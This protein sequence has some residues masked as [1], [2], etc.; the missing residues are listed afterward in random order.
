MKLKAIDAIRFGGLKGACVSDLGDGLTVVLGPNESGKSSLTALAR[1]VLYGYPDG[2]SKERGYVPA[3]GG[4]RAARLVFADAAGEW[5]VE[6][7]DG[8]NRGPV[9][10]ATLAGSARPE[11]LSE[12]VSGVSEQTYKVVFGFGLDELALIEHGDKD[13]VLARLHAAGAG[14]AVNPM[15]ARKRLDDEAKALYLKGASKPQVNALAAQIRD[16][17]LRIA[18]LENVASDYAADQVCLAELAEQLE[19]LRE[20]RDA[21]RAQAHVFEQ[22]TA[23]LEGASEELVVLAGDSRDSRL[24]VERIEKAL[25][26]VDVDERVLAVDAELSAVLDE[27]SGF[28]QRLESLREADVA[29]S[30]VERRAATFALPDGAVDSIENRTAVETWRDRLTGLRGGAE[31]EEYTARQAEAR[32]AGTEQIAAETTAPASGRANSRVLAVVLATIIVAAGLVFAATGVLLRQPIATVLGGAVVAAGAI[33]LVVAITRKPVAA[34]PS[35]LSAAAAT[36]RADA[37]AQRTLATHSSGELDRAFGEWRAWLT[38]RELDAHGEEPAAV[39]AVLEELA[40]RQRLLGEA[41]R[42]RDQAARERDAAE[43]WVIRLVDTVR[44]YDETAAQIPVLSEA[45]VLAA[46]AKHDL[47]AA[48]SSRTDRQQL[49]RELETARTEHQRLAQRETAAKQIIADVAGRFGAEAASA[50]PALRAAFDRAREDLAEVDER[51]ESVKIEHAELRGKLNEEGLGDAMARKRQ[52]LEGL[53]AQAH[54]AADRYLVAALSVRILDRARERF[55][56]ERQPEVVRTAGRVFSAMTNGRYTSLS[57]PLD[58]SGI[59]VVRA[60]GEVCSTGELSRGTAEQLYLALRIGLIGSLG[61]T[62]AS[63]PVLMDDVVVNF[64]P[65]RRAG[66]VTAVA[67]LAAIRQ[68]LFFTCH[69]ETAEALVGSVPGAKLLSLGRCELRG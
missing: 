55:E 31:R 25:A 61:A 27:A 44:R 11:L 20:H 18:E 5:A 29:A 50:V 45:L 21:L 7:V 68:V 34:E 24:A 66:A 65:E 15:D 56:R 12:L 2:R 30:E 48:R 28:R 38:E 39:R 10:I 59:S 54:E 32:A 41:T 47:E 37:V 46:R 69:P 43:A 23:R 1:Y 60:D 52:E 19:P 16:V 40:E 58:N 4:G 33:A 8:K 42:H 17:K 67:E 53:R 49:T 14:L 57:V 22:D 51:F 26:M 63:L 6:R 35:P 36:L 64:D 62:G 13:D 9:S 3:T